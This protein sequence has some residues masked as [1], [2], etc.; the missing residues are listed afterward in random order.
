MVMVP[1]FS[2]SLLPARRAKSQ[3]KNVSSRPQ[4]YYIKVMLCTRR[5]FDNR[6][7]IRQN[8]TMMGRHRCS[9]AI[10]MG[11]LTA[12]LLTVCTIPAAAEDGQDSGDTL[13]RTII[14]LHKARTAVVDQQAGL[15]LEGV[16]SSREQDEAML[17]V[18][19]L[20]G[21]IQ[22]YCRQRYLSTGAAGLEGL[23]CPTGATGKMEAGPFAPLPEN[24]GP[25]RG[26]KVAQLD[27]EL[28]SALGEFDDM[29]LQ[30]EEKVA[31]QIPR[32]GEGGGAASGDW[33]GG[34]SADQGAGSSDTGSEVSSA[35]EQ[36]KKPGG[37]PP[38]SA[39]EQSGKGLS[40]GADQV[41]RPP[42]AGRPDLEEG[43]DDIVARQLREA[44]EQETDPEVKERLWEEYRKYKE[45]I[46]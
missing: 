36:N 13:K 40:G 7:R 21:R 18:A 20:D 5:S 19:Y 9:Y 6:N 27:Q 26:E 34:S 11:A 30:E 28:S 22:Y 41:E 35:S 38:G 10:R 23:P 15:F 24:V 16:A 2:V 44:A 8:V 4:A 39:S 25:T 46:R 31:T 37:R 29:L 17:F 33:Q 1:S 42:T 32:R 43:D 45:G 12:L 3:T 14:S